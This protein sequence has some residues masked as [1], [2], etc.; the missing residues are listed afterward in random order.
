MTKL[1][2]QKSS[3]IILI[4]L[5]VLF[6]SNTAQAQHTDYV[7]DTQKQVLAD[8]TAAHFVPDVSTKNMRWSQTRNKWFTAKLGFAPILDYN[9]NYQDNDSKNQVGNQESR[10]DIRSARIMA[11][12]KI[13]FK[14]KWSYLLSF[15]YRGL[16]RK[17]DQAAF[18]FTDI[19]LIIPLGANSE[20]QVGKQ[21]ETF[22]Y[23]MVGD[24]ANLPHFER[25]MSPF[26]NSRNNGIIYRHFLMKDRM[27]ISAGVFNQWPGNGKNLDEGATTFTARITGLP[28]WENEGKTFM[29]SGIGVR[30]VEAENGVI[31]LKGKNESNIS[32]NYVDTGNMNASHQWNV[33][34]EQLWSLENFSVLMEYVHNW[35]ATTDFGLE[36]FNGYYVTG[37]YVLSGEKRPYDKR[38]AYARRVK[39]T[40]KYGAWEVITRFGKNDLDSRD[41]QGGINNRYDLGL[42]W[43]ATQ[44]WKAGMVYGIS[45]LDKNG[46]T[47]ITNSLQFRLQWIY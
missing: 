13:N 39:P 10:W 46:V 18:G 24:A 47:G 3:V 23:E 41:I 7:D 43:W 15:E 35:T 30:Y 25:L 33:S 14:T 6:C 21:K 12:G 19:K 44:Y 2:N 36:Q 45:N 1:I 38:A 28:K 9:A 5:I 16:D 34:V 17:E 4:S 22:C 40:G 31:R 26:F 42:N 29:H 27:T 11:R 8:S 32:T 37:S 20:L